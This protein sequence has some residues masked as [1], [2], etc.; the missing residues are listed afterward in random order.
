MPGACRALPPQD[1]PAAPAQDG[2]AAKGRPAARSQAAGEGHPEAH[3]QYP[4]AA[5]ARGRS[6]M[7]AQDRPA[8]EGRPAAH[9][10]AAARMRRMPGPAAVPP[11]GRMTGV[12]LA[13]GEN[14][15]MGGRPKA[16]LPFRG[17]PL[18]VRQA[19][20]LR[21]CCDELLIVT[22]A[23][24]LYAPLAGAGVRFVRDRF[25]GQGPLAGI[26]AALREARRPEAWIVACDMPHISAAAAAEMLAQKRRRGVQ[27]AVPRIGGQPQP[28]HGIYSRDAAAAAERL[29]AEGRRAVKAWLAGLTA[30]EA[31]ESF[32]AERGIDPEF[33]VNLNTPEEYRRE[34]ESDSGARE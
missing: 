11:D 9:S 30:W 28:L 3:P 15:R 26:H 20:I 1:R 29:L 19:R 27:A 17:E 21:E 24:E 25:P 5:L 31:D 16:L 12:I 18:I 34:L 4:A 22:A 7:L 13:G 10:Q 32:F 23:P 2:E 6:A 14:R 33:A 8:A